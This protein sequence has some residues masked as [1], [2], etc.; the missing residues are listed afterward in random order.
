MS[1]FK[2]YLTIGACVQ[3]IITTFRFGTCK[4]QN[5][6]KENVSE[7]D[8]KSPKFWLWNVLTFLAGVIVNVLLWPLAI[9]CEIFNTKN[10][11]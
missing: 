1:K 8:K 3:T 4:V 5:Y 9:I 6:W 11:I 7:E 2:K 10:G